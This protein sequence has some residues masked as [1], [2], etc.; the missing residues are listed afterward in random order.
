M[1]IELAPNHKLGLAVQNPIWLAGGAIGYGEALPKGIALSKLGGVVVGPVMASSR[2]GAPPPRL[3]HLNGGA[4]LENGLQNRGAGM[5][6]R[7]FATLWPRLGC[8]VVV[9]IAEG[10]PAGLARLVRKLAEVDG[11]NG[12]ELLCPPSAD[13]ALVAT[14]VGTAERN[15]DW[16]IWVKLPLDTAAGLAL[17]A[18]E[19][20]AAALV[21]GQPLRG[22]AVRRLA[23][24]TQHT[25]CGGVLGPLAF[26]PM[27]AT[28]LA[29]AKL[30]LGCAL[31][32]C[33]GIHTVDHVYQALAA[34]ARAVQIESALWVEPGLPARLA[35]EF[36]G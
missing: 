3:A 2:G 14:L 10:Y 26:A 35:E 29:V 36:A 16:P 6:V 34:G 30:Q 28:L 8:P 33:G 23:D 21:I 12:L 20:G 19:G 9:Q 17:A 18:V 11:I 7:R 24:G 5:A 1:S 13:G 25:L 31:I 32:A 22:A 4:I 27:L 15:C